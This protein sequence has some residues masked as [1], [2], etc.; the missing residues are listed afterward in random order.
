[1]EDPP[2]HY[3]PTRTYWWGIRVGFSVFILFLLGIRSFFP[4]Y[5]VDVTT[6]G[7]V[8]LL[9]F[10]W[11]LPYLTKF[12]LPGGITGEIAGTRAPRRETPV[13]GE[14]ARPAMRT[15]QA[16]LGAVIRSRMRGT[17]TPEERSLFSTLI[18]TAVFLKLENE[19]SAPNFEVQRYPMIIADG[20][21][22]GTSFHAVIR[23]SHWPGRR[24]YYIESAVS[25][26]REERVYGA[27]EDLRRRADYTNRI[28]RNAPNEYILILV[29]DFSENAGRREWLNRVVNQAQVAVAVPSFS[30]ILLDVSELP[31]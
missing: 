28:L 27:L 15:E 13:T 2:D 18:E 7:L 5:P 14:M 1:M 29:A 12:G 31:I 25:G 17:L 6:I 9:I 24:F 11:V 19:Y 3:T 8:A 30:S 23:S 4:S 22:T 16:G 10:I 20:K 26:I 21:P